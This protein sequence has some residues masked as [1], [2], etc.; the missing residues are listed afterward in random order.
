MPK[1]QIL[2]TSVHMGIGGIESVLVNLLNNIN[3]EKYEVDLVLYKNIGINL[4]KIPKEV[5][6]FS[7]FAYK[8]MRIINKLTLND[9][10]LNKL[11]RKIF[12]NS[13]TYKFYISKKQYD[14]GIAFAG[15]HYLMDSFVG[16]SNCL[17][18]YIW[19][20]TDMAYL[21]NNNENFKINF[22]KTAKKYQSFTKII[23]VS[24]SAM[25]AFAKAYTVKSNKLDYIWNIMPTTLSNE[26]TKFDSKGF[27]I[28]SIGRLEHQKGYERLIDIA[29]ILAKKKNNFHIYILGNGSEKDNL[30]AKLEVKKMANF[31]TFLGAQDNVYKYLNASDLFLSTSYYEG[32]CT[33]IIEALL[34]GIPVVAPKVTG[35]VDIAYDLA[36]K[37]SFILTENNTEALAKG[38]EEA[39]AGKVSKNFKFDTVKINKAIV[40]KYE[41]LLA[42]KL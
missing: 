34:C 24:K 25:E 9:G 37:K 36:P 27:N 41:Q 17:K 42:G 38:I 40:A 7:P 35:I 21:F 1:K 8:K 5:H 6:I 22:L 13:F 19:V 32:F 3:Y 39:M 14:V 31:V 15:Y 11:L 10:F 4:K 18:K 33:A 23:A 2:I 29:E 12:F 16:L 20:H 26:K 28:V 30:L